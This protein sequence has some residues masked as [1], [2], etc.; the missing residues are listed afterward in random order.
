MNTLSVHLPFFY[1]L[2]VWSFELRAVDLLGRYS[3]TWANPPTLFYFSYFLERVSHFCL[4]LTLDH[5]PTYASQVTEITATHHIWLA[6][7][8]GIWLTFCPGWPQTAIL[9]VYAFLVAEIIGIPG[10]I[11]LQIIRFLLDISFSTFWTISESV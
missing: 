4:Q 5:G 2:A 8:N 9:P 1:F 10:P 6:G 7:W 11:L 3:T